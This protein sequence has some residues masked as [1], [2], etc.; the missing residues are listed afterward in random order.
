MSGPVLRD[1]ATR[2]KRMRRGWRSSA[3]IDQAHSPKF[4]GGRDDRQV[5][6]INNRGW[7]I[8]TLA[9][10]ESG[11]GLQF[12]P[13]SQHRQV[14]K[15]GETKGA[16]GTFDGQGLTEYEGNRIGREKWGKRTKPPNPSEPQ[17]RGYTATKKKNR[18]PKKGSG[19]GKVQD[20]D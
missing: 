1:R 19:T 4:P 2:C 11:P 12:P 13:P 8:A 16:R 15:E 3:Y 18:R 5:L 20:A 9:T 14:D 17:Q 7:T 10:R 6:G